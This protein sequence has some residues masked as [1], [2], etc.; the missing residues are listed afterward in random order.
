MKELIALSKSISRSLRRCLTSRSLL[1]S[2]LL[3]SWLLLLMRQMAPPIAAVL[4][5]LVVQ[6][7]VFIATTVFLGSGRAG[8]NRPVDSR[9][10]I[11]NLPSVIA[12]AMTALLLHLVLVAATVWP[13][14]SLLPF[15]ASSA[16]ATFV[17]V[18]MGIV[19]SARLVSRANYSF[20][21]LLKGAFL[22]LPLVLLVAGL[23]TLL[24]ESAVA[25]PLTIAIFD[26]STAVLAATS[27]FV[28]ESRLA[29]RPN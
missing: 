7:A 21:Q 4:F 16:G 25:S 29:F 2:V 1:F 8:G 15:V 14:V 3:G 18:L 13:S 24:L 20:G 6:V 27:Y 28:A 17:F 26:V 5:C 23:G 12:P 10:L 9:W 11:A 22:G 19:P